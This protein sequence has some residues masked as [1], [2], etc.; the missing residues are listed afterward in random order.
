[1]LP[2]SKT[3]ILLLPPPLPSVG[4]GIPPPPS[5]A[6]TDITVT[7]PS[8]KKISGKNVGKTLLLLTF[9]S[10]LLHTQLR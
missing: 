7:I 6:M 3:T 9:L 8:L 5:G 2:L 4:D 1:M 10:G